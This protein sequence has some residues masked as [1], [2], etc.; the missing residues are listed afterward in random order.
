MF[1]VTALVVYSIAIMDAVMLQFYIIHFRKLLFYLCVAYR[2]E[3]KRNRCNL[4]MVLPTPAL[5]GCSSYFNISYGSNVQGGP[6]QYL[7]TIF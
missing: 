3:L 5:I 4:F 7:W 1:S 2:T 6:K